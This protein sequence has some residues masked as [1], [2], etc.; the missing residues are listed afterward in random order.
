MRAAQIIALLLPESKQDAHPDA[1]A[2]DTTTALMR[3]EDG[4]MSLKPVTKDMPFL[5]QM[6]TTGCFRRGKPII[7]P[8]SR[9]I[10]GYEMEMIAAPEARLAGARLQLGF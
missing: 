10:I 1:F 2:V 5:E 3:D 9:E 7:D 8:L 4:R 6:M